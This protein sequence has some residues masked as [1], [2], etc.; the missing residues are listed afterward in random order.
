VPVLECARCNEL[1]YSAH[2]ATDL[3]CDACGAG[4]WR[5]FED[6]V[7]FTRVAELPRRFARGDHG[8]MVYTDLD[9]AAQ[10]C[11]DFLRTG[12]GAGE[13]TI[14]VLTDP[15][16]TA[17]EHQL[18]PEERSAVESHPP[19][20]L[21]KDFDAAVVVERFTAFVTETER[22]VR[23]VSG[24]AP[25][26]ISDV[27]LDEWR[28]YEKLAHECTIELR[29]TVLCTYDS[30]TLPIAFSP[31]AVESHTLISHNG[32]ELVRNSEFEYGT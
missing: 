27:P 32:G 3:S 4:V 12:I 26:F 18:T 30:N 8:V 2:G 10:F 28:R 16:R 23:I 15:L 1:Y 6:E 17:T 21:Y 31:V 13:R 29:A 11:A 7:S 14:M 22:A 5:V 25:E 19:A 9:G 20:E 24:P